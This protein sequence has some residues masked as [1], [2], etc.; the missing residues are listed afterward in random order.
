MIFL[1][2]LINMFN[3]EQR[4]LFIDLFD[5]L[6]FEIEEMGYSHIED[7]MELINEMLDNHL[8]IYFEDDV[9]LKWLS[10]YILK[11]QGK[12][13][14]KVMGICLNLGIEI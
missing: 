3:K 8:G 9:Q 6:S 10:E 7:Q 4:E 2:Q 5:D 1:V 12:L 13:E 14:N 11:N